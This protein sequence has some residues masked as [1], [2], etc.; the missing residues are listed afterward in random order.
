MTTVRQLLDL[1]QLC[2]SEGRFEDAE[3]AFE[4][5]TELEPGSVE[6]L[7][8]RA[9]ALDRLRAWGEA[10]PLLRRARALAPDDERIWLALRGHLLRFRL[11]EEAFEDFR[12]FEAGA[13]LSAPLVIAGLV[14]ARFAPDCQYEARYLPLALDWPYGRGEARYA[15]AALTHAEYFDVSRATLKRLHETH[16][17]LR[18]EERGGVPDLATRRTPAAGPLR[19]G[20]LSAD[21]RSH[22][23]G[24]LMLEVLRHHDRGRF[25][26]RAYSIGKHELEDAL[27]DEFRACCEEFVRLDELDDLA[28]AKRIA[29]DD[30]DLLIDLMCHSGSSRPSILLY[31]P[32]PVIVTHLG[33]HGPLG[34]QQVDFK[35]GDRHVDLPD[36]G[37]Y[38]IETPLPLG[39]CVLSVRRVAPAPTTVPREAIG[40]D[41]EAVLFGTFV[42]LRKLSSRCL[43]L[44]RAILDRVPHA[45]LAFSPSRETNRPLYR[46]RLRGFGI[47]DERICFIPRTMDDAADRARYRLVDVVLDTLPYT[48]GD[49]TAAALD[50]GV[51]VVTR[52]GERAAERMTWSLLAH[53][54]VTDTAAHSDAEYVETAC[55]LADDVEWRSTI[56]A[57][58]ADRLPRSGLADFER[59]TRALEAAY[60]SAIALKLTRPG[61]A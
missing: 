32:A 22:V 5:A 31:K 30:L 49:T 14:S 44:W 56:S 18:Q 36:A 17:R 37:E 8:N 59:Y 4:R 16:N 11:N 1:G 47:P 43:T 26:V 10:L 27:T 50:M 39:C 53:L 7:F 34:L 33:S 3:R 58:I 61:G 41:R 15:A 6:A 45:V 23:M 55:R 29:A 25:H 12:V 52:V 57:A 9:L 48:G 54:G 28:A 21:F 51:P 42:D 46:R 35:L 24:R 13:K 40:I 20:Y 38:Q 19:I 60:E 2:F